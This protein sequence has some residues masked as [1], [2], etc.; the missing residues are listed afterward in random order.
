MSKE[1]FEVTRERFHL[2]NPSI[3]IVQGTWP[4]EA[5]LFAYLDG[6]EVEAELEQQEYVSVMERFQDMDAVDGERVSVK[7]ILPEN[8]EDYRRLRIYGENRGRRF[9]W[10]SIAV[11]E[12]IKKQGKPYYYIEE[13]QIE[14]KTCRIRGWAVFSGPVKICVY[15]QDRKKIPFTIQ[16]TARVDVE[17]MFQ[18]GNISDKCGFFIEAPNVQGR[19]LYLVFYGQETRAIH[20]VPLSRAVILKNKAEKYAVRGLQY[21]KSQ[22]PSALADKIAGKIHNVRLKPMPYE[23]WIVR[24]LPDKRELQAQRR[25]VFQKEPKISIVVPLYRTPE[26]YLK[27]LI[28]SVKQQ[29]YTNWEL[30]LSDGSGKDSVLPQIL[31][32]YSEDSRIKT[33]FSESGLRIS[34]NTNAAIGLATGDYIAFV[35]HDDELTPNALYECVKAVN[36]KDNVRIL[37]SDEDKMTMDGHKFFQPHFKPDF[38]MDLLRTVNYICH[39][40]VAE[41]GLL[42]RVGF[43]CPEFDGAQDYDLILRCVEAAAAEEIVHIPKILYHWRC[44]EDSTAEN[45]ES[46]LYA[47]D[48]GERVLKAHYERMGIRAEVTKGEYLGLYRTRYIRDSEPLIS[49][50]IPNKDHVEDLKRCIDS[51]EKKSVYQ[52]FEFIIVE[53][54]STEE[55]TFRFYEELQST[56]KR[57]QLVYWEG[58]FNYSAINNFGETYAKGEYLLLLNNDTEMINPDCLE[59]LLGYC[60]RSDVGAVG[61]RLYYEDDTIQHAGVVI[62]FGGLAGHCF[63]QQP[64][65]TSGYCHRIICAQNYS[66][67][68]AACM[69]VRKSVFEE[70]GGFSEEL[71]V[72]FNDID[73]CMKLRKAG[74][75]IVYNPYAELYHY[76][77]KSRGMEDTPEKVER[78][79]KEIAA[80]E[81][82]WPDIL[83][84]GDPY[85]NPN[86]SLNTQDFSLK[87]I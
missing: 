13:E 60:M 43:L 45:P 14:D 48:A 4:K 17:K 56:D 85:Y 61:A 19:Y 40:F 29:T 75:L 20:M 30:C 15:G 2:E 27:R 63:V 18:E 44:H 11:R 16:R 36:Q 78:F 10:F 39:L 62:G 59:E 76:E 77:S 24:H 81:K 32:K 86:L 26:K 22:G 21:L 25:E 7:L 58:E 33:V 31:E 3:Y 46:K 47:F 68:T 51:I 70:V 65:G 8:L 38:N 23:K 71:R 55:E 9:C 73:F 28:E 67:V 64:R 80:F 52:N 84:D 42:E 5:E 34:E 54:N 83:R 49:I 41:R 57:V 53:N 79:N 50:I 12:L 72:A 69:M 87:R 35:D 66:A 6:T 1:I 82:K 74:Y 37:Y